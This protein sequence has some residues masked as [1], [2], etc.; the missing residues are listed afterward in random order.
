M[1]RLA[2]HCLIAIAWF[3]GGWAIGSWITGPL[4][5]AGIALAVSMAAAI[6]A[7]LITRCAQRRMRAARQAVWDRR[8]EEA[9]QQRP[10]LTIIKGGKEPDWINA[11]YWRLP[12]NPFDEKWRD[13]KEAE[14]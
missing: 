9:R 1:T 12:A 6:A 10:D 8:I 13:D 3:A 2:H 5:Q 7:E 14:R 4:R 11:P